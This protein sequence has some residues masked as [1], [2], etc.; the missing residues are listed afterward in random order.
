MEFTML[1]LKKTT[2]IIMIFLM[3]FILTSCK[4]TNKDEKQMETKQQSTELLI[5]EKQDV[6]IYDKKFAAVVNGEIIYTNMGSSSCPPIIE[7]ALINNNDTYELHIIDN[8]GKIC[9]KDLKSLQQK[10]T[11]TDGQ[12]IP[13]NAKIKLIDPSDK[14]TDRKNN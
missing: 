1:K 5:S 6:K 14:K 12:K 8:T 10:I 7:K 13:E 3:I 4:N 2:G 9:T 11:R